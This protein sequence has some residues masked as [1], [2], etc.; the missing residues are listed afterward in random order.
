MKVAF[1]LTLLMLVNPPA[2]VQPVATA[3]AAYNMSL[4]APWTAKLRK[5]APG[6]L[7]LN[8]M[9]RRGSMLGTG[10]K[11]AD[12]EGL[13][14]ADLDSGKPVTFVLRREA[15]TVTFS[16]RFR[17]GEGEGTLRYDGDADYW[18]RITAMGIANDW[19]E[20]RT[21]LLALPLLDV[22]TDY[23]AALRRE[24]AMG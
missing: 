11:L 14:T 6:E 10:V 16:G 1:A 8:V 20:R 13:S 15:G 5:S 22:R 24:G 2:D 18:S 17:D 19:S 21:Q 3:A 12:L 7:Q 9:E 4:E 23:I